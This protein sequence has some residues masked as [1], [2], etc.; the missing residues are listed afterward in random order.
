MPVWAEATV[1]KILEDVRERNLGIKEWIL[2]PQSEIRRV[3]E[4]LNESG[5]Q[6]VKEDMVLDEEKFYPMMKVVKGDRDVYR[7]EELCYGKLLLQSKNPILKT[8]LEKELELKNGIY[9]KLKKTSGESA[10][11][12]VMELE[13]DISLIQEALHIYAL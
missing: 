8:F 1:I 3:R 2:Q 5:Y 4:Y 13:S 7:E 12:R 10:K 11:K 9:E 6:I